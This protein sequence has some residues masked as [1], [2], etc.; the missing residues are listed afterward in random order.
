MKI[1]QAPRATEVTLQCISLYYTVM[2]VK[3]DYH[4]HLKAAAVMQFQPLLTYTNDGEDLPDFFK[5]FQ[6]KKQLFGFFS[7]IFLIY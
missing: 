4:P 3:P 2:V 5:I 7:E 1:L 6:E